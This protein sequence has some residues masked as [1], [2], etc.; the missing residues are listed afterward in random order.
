MGGIINCFAVLA[1][2]KEWFAMTRKT[3]KMKM[4]RFSR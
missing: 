2:T 4:G 3:F 1:M